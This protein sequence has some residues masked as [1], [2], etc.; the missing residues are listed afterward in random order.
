M[1]SGAREKTSDNPSGREADDGHHERAG[2]QVRGV[3]GACPRPRQLRQWRE[4]RARERQ[5]DHQGGHHRSLFSA[6][7]LFGLVRPCMRAS[8]KRRCAADDGGEADSGGEPE[9]YCQQAGGGDDQK[10]ESS[11]AGHRP[12]MPRV[13]LARAG[14]QM[15]GSG[16]ACAQPGAPRPP[17]GDRAARTRPPRGE[18]TGAVTAD[19]RMSAVYAAVPAQLSNPWQKGGLYRY[20]RQLLTDLI[21]VQVAAGSAQVSATGG[22][23]IAVDVWI[24]TEFRRAGLDPDAVWPRAERPRS[25]SQA[26]TRAA[27][28]FR[29]SRL[30]PERAIQEAAIAQLLDRAGSSRSNVLGGYFQKEIDVVVAAEDRGLEL[31]VSTKSMTGS[32]GKNLG[33]RFEEAAGDLANIRRRYPLATFGYGYLATANV[34]DEPASWERLK[35]MLRKLRSLSTSDETASYDATCLVVVDWE[36]GQVKLDDASVPD[37]LS[38]DRFFATML[39]RLFS[40]SPVSEH[41]SA[42]ALWAASEPADAEL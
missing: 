36:S 5:D 11:K 39:R 40:R 8:D 32:F 35:D 13:A 9:R 7:L 31:G 4:Q 22:L 29:Y 27:S 3:S 17:G 14:L 10:A 21:A 42:R 34:F 15:V 23:A 12:R 41:A 28:T 1:P 37:D 25:V 26:L 33:N 30:A 18:V 20:D 24:A 38:P 2:Q 16:P 6:R 19:D